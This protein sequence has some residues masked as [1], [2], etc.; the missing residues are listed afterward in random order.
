VLYSASVDYE[1]EDAHFVPSPLLPERDAAYV[2]VAVR[3]A[4]SKHRTVVLSADEIA[5]FLRSLGNLRG[6]PGMLDVDAALLLFFR[7]VAGWNAEVAWLTGEGADETF[8]GYPWAE[9]AFFGAAVAHQ[10]GRRTDVRL[11]FPWMRHVEERLALLR[12]EVAQ[13]VWAYLDELLLRAVEST[14]RHLPE[15]LSRSV[16]QKEV[17]VL[18]TSAHTAL[19]FGSVLLERM[20]RSGKAAGLRILFPFLDGDVR[21][22]APFAL[23]GEPSLRKPLLREALTGIVPEE[24]RLRKKSPFPKSHHPKLAQALRTRGEE[25]MAN[26][27]ATIWTFLDR[28]AASRFLQS[29][30]PHLPWFGQLLDAPHYAAYLAEVHDWLERV[31]TRLP[32]RGF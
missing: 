31:R 5:S 30:P 26:P 3:A 32:D 25:L 2:E 8:A 10:S 7:R 18:W 15:E 23:R 21:A 28:D 12:P 16:P 24:I 27:Q 11:L 4:K 29:P 20:A 9:E 6:F 13:A 17:A 1:D 14:D 19:H 22:F